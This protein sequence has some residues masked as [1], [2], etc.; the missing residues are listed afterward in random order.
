[1][2]PKDKEDVVIGIERRRF[3]PLCYIFGQTTI[4]LI[5]AEL[6]WDKDKAAEGARRMKGEEGD[7]II[8]KQLYLIWT[9][10]IAFGWQRGNNLLW[11]WKSLSQKRKLIFDCHL[12]QYWGKSFYQISNKEW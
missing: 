2:P 10:S 9:K 12:S 3:I 5:N 7:V 6:K 11:G 4:H 1:M 8:T